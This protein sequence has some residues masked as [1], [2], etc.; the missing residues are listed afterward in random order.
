ML[1]ALVT[2]KCAEIRSAMRPIATPVVLTPAIRETLTRFL[3]RLDASAVTGEGTA[4]TQKS[5]SN[6]E[7]AVMDMLGVPEV[8]KSDKKKGVACLPPFT[9]DYFG[10]TRPAVH[11]RNECR[12]VMPE[13]DGVYSIHSPY[14]SQCNPDVLLLDIRKGEIAC[15]FGIEVK[16]GGPTWNTHVQFSRRNLLYVAFKDVPHYFFGDHIRTQESWIYALAWDE[17]QRELAQEINTRAGTAG[18]ANLCVAYPKQEFR[19]LDL[20]AGRDARHAEIKAWVQTVA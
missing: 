9:D 3:E 6:T 20:N 14:G 10:F 1:A 17:I 7:R 16:S 2:A 18:L 12:F 13:A 11:H 15:S 4:E 5:S 8:R 19:G